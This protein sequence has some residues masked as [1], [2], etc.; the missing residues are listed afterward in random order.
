[1]THRLA[2]YG[3]LRRGEVNHHVV[4]GIAG[5]WR[6]GVV[7]G[8]VYEISWGP[9]TGYPGLTL[10]ADGPAVAVDVI[11]CD[12]LERHLPMLD[13]FEGEGYRRV[14]SEVDVDGERVE[15]W[16]YEAITDE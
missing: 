5:T 6:S 13:R 2:V 15:A 10:D 16:V 8:W 7:P 4:S 12:D 11:E 1:M 9:A 3:T 14:V